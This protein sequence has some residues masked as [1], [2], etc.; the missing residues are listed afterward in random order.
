MSQFL[1]FLTKSIAKLIKS[2]KS[3]AIHVKAVENIPELIVSH[4]Q[5]A[6][7][8]LKIIIRPHFTMQRLLQQ[9]SVTTLFEGLFTS[10]FTNKAF[11]H[12]CGA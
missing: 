12:C 7:Q 4:V 5:F 6:V 3:V 1:V 11:T 10:P 8:T 9:K 2:Q